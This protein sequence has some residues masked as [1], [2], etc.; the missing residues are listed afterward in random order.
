MEPYTHIYICMY[1]CMHVFINV[2]MHA[3]FCLTL[4]D[5][6]DYS[7]PGSSVHGIF[8][9][10]LEWA[11]SPSS[12]GSSHPCVPW[13]EHTSLVS[14]AFIGGFYTIEPTEK[15]HKFIRYVTLFT[16]QNSFLWFCLFSAIFFS[17][18]HFMYV[19]INKFINICLYKYIYVFKYIL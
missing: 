4:L 2:C 10:I 16:F 5:P 6:M 14:S 15:P 18:L 11:A 3:Q 7:P 9:G 12:R 13:L 1:I 19:N 17:L 8:Q